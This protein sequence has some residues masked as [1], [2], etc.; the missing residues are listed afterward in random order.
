MEGGGHHRGQGLALARLHLDHPPLREGERRDHLNVEVPQADGAGGGF[1]NEGEE[2]GL[3][4]V[5]VAAGPSAG[6][7]PGRPMRDL[8][9]GQAADVVP[10]VGDC[11]ERRVERAQVEMDRRASEA[12]D[13]V[14]PSHAV[15]HAGADTRRCGHGNLLRIHP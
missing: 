7:Q 8:L 3:Q 15:A 1:P 10:E 2:Q 9:V 14:A 13:P 4:L 5:E 12:R 6:A 11:L